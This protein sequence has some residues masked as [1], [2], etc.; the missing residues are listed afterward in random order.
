[1][2]RNRAE[3]PSPVILSDPF[4]PVPAPESLRNDLVAF[5]SGQIFIREELRGKKDIDDYLSRISEFLEA[6]GRLSS[7]TVDWV[8]D[9][10][11]SDL[12][13]TIRKSDEEDEESENWVGNEFADEIDLFPETL[14][15]TTVAEQVPDPEIPSSEGP[16]SEEVDEGQET[17]GKAL[18]DSA[19]MKQE[20]PN[21]GEGEQKLECLS[22][23]AGSTMTIFRASPE[24]AP[25]VLLFS[26]GR[27]YVSRE[28]RDNQHVNYYCRH[29]V[30]ELW[31]K[32]FPGVTIPRPQFV[33]Y[34]TLR[35]IRRDAFPEELATGDYQA[36]GD[37]A[38]KV[39]EIIRDAIARKASDIH[40]R[41]EKDRTRILYRVH[42]WLKPVQTLTHDEGERLARIVYNTM[43]DSSGRDTM[44]SDKKPQDGQ[45]RQ[46]YL[47]RGIFNIR[48]FHAPTLGAGLGTV[49][50]VLRLQ[51]GS[52]GEAAQVTDIDTLGY[53]ARHLAQIRFLMGLSHGIILFAGPMG[54][55]KSTS[56]AS[57]L[58]IVLA[59]NPVE[60]GRGLHL[61]TLEDPPEYVIPT[62]SQIAVP[63]G[64]FSEVLGR[65]MRFDANILM[66][67]EIRDEATAEKAIE[68]AMSGHVVYSTVHANDVLSI[69]RRLDG[70]KVRRDLLADPTIFRGMVCQRLVPVLCRECRMPFRE[71]ETSGILSGDLSGRIARVELSE[72][73][74]FF[75]RR[76]GCR[77]CDNQG[78]IG[79]TVV[80]EI[81]IPDQE[82]LNLVAD[83]RMTEAWRYFSEDLEGR[84][85]MDHA[86]E[87]IRSGDVDPRDVESRL[88]WLH[89]GI[90]D[91]KT[92]QG[93]VGGLA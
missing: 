20:K 87:K 88:G 62:A 50:M 35:K 45:F 73:N 1:M 46:D 15:E 13:R 21:S 9:R 89:R 84:T 63:G 47:P 44:F 78:I 27:F 92:V 83:G 58:A 16:E 52:G 93:I 55:G 42:G 61:V 80:A 39:L 14:P 22:S 77:H 81:L 71:A 34:E 28:H 17:S 91:Q 19:Q 32:V 30:P 37:D 60:E 90:L 65:I 59:M 2:T 6:S 72:D 75:R 74:I 53:D 12:F 57:V 76:E 40:I 24:I 41:I 7:L 23:P 29:F 51:Y 8:P 82:I 70:L 54:S 67:G 26:D 31:S 69:P 25:M 48:E 11:L 43:L 79:R 56:M 10:T 3:T 66:I 68:G 49:T 38:R 18:A 36:S 86:I 4:G 64:K 85:M 5:E 33:S